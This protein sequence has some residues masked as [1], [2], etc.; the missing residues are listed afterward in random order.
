MPYITTPSK[1]YAEN[2]SFGGAENLTNLQAAVESAMTA[3]ELGDSG[4][5]VTVDASIVVLRNTNVVQDASIGALR[6]ADNTFATNAS[7]GLNMIS[8]SAFVYVVDGSLSWVAPDGSTWTWA[9]TKP[10]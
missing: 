5:I 1:A 7:V 4:A 2:E 9:V 10:V 3:L 6:L 8:K